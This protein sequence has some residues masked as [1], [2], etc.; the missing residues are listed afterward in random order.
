MTEPAVLTERRDHVLIIT[1]N[2]PEARNAVNRALALG[3]EKAI[4]LLEDDDDLWAAILMGTGPV[5]CAGADLKAVA[6]GTFE[7]LR[8]ERGG[9]AG[10]VQRDRTKPVIAALTGDAIAGGLEIAIAADLIV[11]GSNVHLGIPEAGRS[12]LAIGGGLAELPRLIGE[13]AALELALTATPWPASR[14]ASLG[15]ISRIVEPPAVLGAALSLAE[16]ICVNAPLA[17]RA[18]RRVIVGGRDLDSN[19]RWALAERELARLAQ[20][21]D[22][23]EGPR[24]FVEKRAPRWSGR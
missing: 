10:F 7:E 16:S 9:F 24:S 13:K 8:T 17:V 18:S 23:K 3:L 14:L 2:R 11:A 15:L 1:L 6:A 20:T 21:A 5:F 19:A 12:L 22:Y 4:D